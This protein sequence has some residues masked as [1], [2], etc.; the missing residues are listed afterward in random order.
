MLDALFCGTAEEGPAPTHAKGKRHRSHRTEKEKA[1]KRQR[2]QEKEARRAS[3]VDEELRQRR[4][5]ERAAGASSSAPVAEVQPILRGVVSTTDGAERLIESTTEGARIAEV[6]TTEGA[7]TDVPEGSGT[8]DPLL[9]DD[10]PALCATGLLH[11][12]PFSF[13]VYV[14]IVDNCI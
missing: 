3:I 5:C 11:S 12:N 4:V 9:V 14:C 10:S 7:P 8:P 13:T 2:W 6:G 1:H